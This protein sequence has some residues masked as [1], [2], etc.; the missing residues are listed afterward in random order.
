MVNEVNLVSHVNLYNLCL[1]KIQEQGFGVVVYQTETHTR[2]E[3][4]KAGVN[5]L[6]SN[7]IELYGLIHLS[8]KYGNAH[9]VEVPDVVNTL[10]HVDE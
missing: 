4:H 6:A 8:A 1:L 2:Y 7:P 9:E 5:L 10:V 3:A